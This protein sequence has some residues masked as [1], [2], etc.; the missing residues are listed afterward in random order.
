ME[1]RN[2]AVVGNSVLRRFAIELM[3]SIADVKVSEDGGPRTVERASTGAYVESDWLARAEEMIL[4][5]ERHDWHPGMGCV[6]HRGNTTV[7]FYRREHVPRWVESSAFK[8]VVVSRP[9]D[10]VLYGGEFFP[11]GA[12]ATHQR[13]VEDQMHDFGIEMNEA[14]ESIRLHG[15]SGPVIK[16][17]VPGNAPPGG[18]DFES[19]LPLLSRKDGII[20]LDLHT[21]L[22]RGRQLNYQDDIHP[23]RLSMRP[24]VDLLLGEICGESAS[25]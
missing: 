15:I 23:S 9:F 24:A 7:S 5:R 1:T 6:L 17:V 10:I 11:M 16:I 8:K 19:L 25:A 22:V 21:M 12:R 20:A 14:L 13:S 18:V 2:I 4:C 3:R